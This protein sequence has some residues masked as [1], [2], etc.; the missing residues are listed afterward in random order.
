MVASILKLNGTEIKTLFALVG[1]AGQGGRVGVT[2]AELA[3]MVGVSANTLRGALRSLNA[4]GIWNDSASEID[5]ELAYSL[6]IPV[7]AGVVKNAIF[8][9]SAI[10]Y[11]KTDSV[12]SS[13]TQKL[14]TECAKIDDLPKSSNACANIASFTN[15]KDITLTK[16]KVGTA[17]VP[18]GTPVVVEPE[19]ENA[20]PLAGPTDDDSEFAAESFEEMAA[21][22]ADIDPD[23]VCI[24]PTP[25]FNKL[26]VEYG[27]DVPVAAIRQFYLD[28]RTLADLENPAHFKPY[29]RRIC[30]R[31]KTEGLPAPAGPIVTTSANNPYTPDESYDKY[32]DPKQFNGLPSSAVYADLVTESE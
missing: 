25:W 23:A 9:D 20:V 19:N 21:L 27:A 22:W 7:F 12:P 13:N 14:T 4:F 15:V 8:D 11:A 1:L 18:N 31:L 16:V 30:D 29:F 24:D 28:D 10:K 2:R 32:S 17:S 6:T 5:V 3:L 26:I